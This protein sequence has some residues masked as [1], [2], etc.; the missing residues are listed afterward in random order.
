M[1]GYELARMRTWKGC[2]GWLNASLGRVRERRNPRVTTAA[3]NVST[4]VIVSGYH[5]A[6]AVW[7]ERMKRVG[8]H[9]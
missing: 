9:R 8:T 7:V 4:R 3:M 1:L 2:N 5:F 6:I